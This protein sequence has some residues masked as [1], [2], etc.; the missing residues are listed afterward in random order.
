MALEPLALRFRAVREGLVFVCE[1]P[2]SR[3]DRWPATLD[4]GE[5]FAF[6]REVTCDTPLPGRY[7]VEVYGRPRSADWS[8]ERAYD[9]FALQIDPGA[10]PPVRL[11]WAPSLFGA[12]SG[13]RD[14]RPTKDP[15]GARIVVAMINSTPV[16][17]TLARVHATMRIRRRGSSVQACPDRGADL[18]FVGSLA[19]GGVQRLSTPLGC[20][21]S[22]EALYDVEVWVANASGASVRLATHT[23]RVTVNAPTSPGP[24]DDPKGKPGGT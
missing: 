20:D 21:I 1:A 16:A 13:T 15:G 11:P 10:N 14:M 5:T 17:V 2:R 6:S 24:Q 22:A 23:I 7:D 3:E 12:A 19:P 18:G 8:P 4:A 9:S